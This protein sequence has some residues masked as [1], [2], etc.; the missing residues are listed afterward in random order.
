VFLNACSTSKQSASYEPPGFPNQWIHGQGALAVMATLC[1]VPD[2]FAHTFARKFYDVLL[3][4]L[5]K[6]DAPGSARNR[7]VAEALLQTR[8]YFMETYNNPL[9][10]AYVLYAYKGAHVLADFA[11]LGVTPLLPDEKCL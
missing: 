10:L 8:R 3:G 6:P 2:Y 9:G 5:A 4:A 11:P 7:Y 1:P